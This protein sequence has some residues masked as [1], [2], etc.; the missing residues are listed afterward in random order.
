[1]MRVLPFVRQFRPDALP[2][3][4]K[5]DSRVMENCRENKEWRKACMRLLLEAYK[6][7]QDKEALAMPEE[8][9]EAS[10]VYLNGF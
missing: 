4:V 1:M 9:M 2:G 6:G 7:I 10:E 3:Q 5:M 8:V